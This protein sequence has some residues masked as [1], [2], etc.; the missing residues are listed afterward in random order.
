MTKPICLNIEEIKKL[1]PHRYPF[2]LVDRVLDLKIGE[3]I[4]AIKNITANEE[5]FNGHFPNHPVMPGVLTIEMCAQAAGVLCVYS[6][7]NSEDQDKKINLNDSSSLTDKFVF[8]LT[9]VDKT[10]FR[11]TMTPGDQL[12]IN[13]KVLQKSSVMWKFYGEILI[14]NDP[15]KKGMET[16]FSAFIKFIG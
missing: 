1:I 13:I 4:T 2:L 10:R 16:E 14:N 11:N 12:F 9:S 6:I 15:G 5:V 7:L 8:Y 3:S